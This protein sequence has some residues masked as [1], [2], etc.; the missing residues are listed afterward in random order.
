MG[1]QRAKQLKAELARIRHQGKPRLLLQHLSELEQLEPREGSWPHRAAEVHRRQGDTG[2]EVAALLR[3]AKK[4]RESGF[5]LKAIAVCKRVLEID[6]THAAAQ[7]VL[8]GL[9][10]QRGMPLQSPPSADEATRAGAAGPEKVRASESVPSVASSAVPEE[11]ATATINLEEIVLTEVIASGPATGL[12]DAH[13]TGGGLAEID[14]AGTD[15]HDAPRSGSAATHAH[16]PDE[17]SELLH[18]T[19]LFS[20][21]SPHD[22]DL[23]IQGAEVVHAAEG[24]DIFHEGDLGDALFVIVEGAITLISDTPKRRMLA[25]LAE[26]QFF[27]E[28]ALLRSEARNATARAVVDTTL[29]RVD[30]NLIRRLIARSP[31][32]LVVLLCFLRDRMTQR[33]MRTSPLFEGLSRAEQVKLGRQFRFLE[34]VPGTLLIRQGQR[35]PALYFVLSGQLEVLATTPSGTPER[36]ASLEPGDVFGEMSLIADEPAVASVRASSKC[37]ILYMTG[38]EVRDVIEDPRIR[39]RIQALIRARRSGRGRDEWRADPV[40]DHQISLD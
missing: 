4:F 29:L 25:A 33:L 17:A 38:D 32:V 30:Q 8:S 12:I 10:E 16:K 19:P 22:L 27:G 13:A 23:L 3:A 39:V 2:A 36:I 26:G 11:A 34:A 37:W 6:A 5:L 18:H 24:N 31:H 9:S 14:L 7:T 35:S 21:L 20:S 40:S 28:S 1:A 15:A